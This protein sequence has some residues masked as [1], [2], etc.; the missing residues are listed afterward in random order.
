MLNFITGQLKSDVENTAAIFAAIWQRKPIIFIVK[1]NG[2]SDSIFETIFNFVPDYRQLIICGHISKKIFYEYKSAKKINGDDSGSLLET[3]HSCYK[4]DGTLSPPI[5][6][7]YSEAQGKDFVNVLSQI[8][9]G[10]IATTTM[11]KNQVVESLNTSTLH[12]IEFD[13]VF[14]LFP[15][16]RP[17][18]MA[19]EKQVI[20]KTKYRV[21]TVAKFILQRKM[22]EVNFVCRTFLNE[23]EKGQIINQVEAEEQFDIDSLTFNRALKLLKAEYHITP[24]AYIQFASQVVSKFLERFVKINGVIAAMAGKKDKIIALKKIEKSI[25]ITSDLFLPFVNML[26]LTKD[27]PVWGED[28]SLT[29]KLK[30]K[31]K[32][33]Y[34]YKM[35]PPEKEYIGFA[36]LLEPSI[37]LALFMSEMENIFK[38]YESFIV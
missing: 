20:L 27:Q 2:N 9:Y 38:E 14:V 12:E 15:E 11:N 17:D 35:F 34:C 36:F 18:D 4:E 19:L 33:I 6:L 31:L 8:N 1:N 30:N 29:I 26:E 7:F 28:I 5:Q 22:S 32:L 23:I 25:P 13:E 37:Q 16:G 21:P 10:W 3:L 24:N